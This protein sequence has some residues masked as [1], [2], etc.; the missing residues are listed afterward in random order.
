MGDDI[1]LAQQLAPVSSF[2]V[3]FSDFKKL[4]QI[5]SGAYSN[6]YLAIHIPSNY[7]VALKVLTSKKLEGTAKVYFVREVMILA[8]CNN[9]FLISLLGYTDTYPYCIA[10]PYVDNGSLYDA[11]KHNPGAPELDNTDKTIIAMCVAYGM[12]SLHALSIIHRD[13]KSLNILLD[14]NCLPKIIDFGISRFHGE[15]GELVTV[16]IGT[17]HWMAPEM[18]DSSHY[19]NKVDVYSFAILLWEML[20][21]ETPFEGM[22]AFQI[23]LG[24]TQNNQ[25]PPI[26]EDTP[27]GL[28]TLIENCW[29]SNPKDRP[30]FVEIFQTFA[31]H[32]AEFADTDQ[33]K[34]DA[35]VG[36]IQQ[37]EQSKSQQS[38][39]QQELFQQQIQQI[40][41]ENMKEPKLVTKSDKPKTVSD[42]ASN[43]HRRTS[44]RE[45]HTK[46]VKRQ[47][48][49]SNEP[50]TDEHVYSNEMHRNK[51]LQRQ[52]RDSD[53][54]LSNQIQFVRH[55]SYSPQ[56][57]DLLHANSYAPAAFLENSFGIDMSIITDTTSPSF[58]SNMRSITSQLTTY[59][60]EEFFQITADNL[61]HDLDEETAICIF[62]CVSKLL[63]K[64][65]TFLQSF[66]DTDC[67]EYM[68]CSTSQLCKSLLRIVLIISKVEPE[69]VPLRI[70]NESFQFANENAQR[71]VC[72]LSSFH[73][74]FS[75]NPNFQMI[76]QLYVANYAQLLVSDEAVNFLLV[77]YQ[78]YRSQ[79]T[80]TFISQV[81]SK[82]LLSNVPEVITTGYKSLCSMP[83]NFKQLPLEVIVSHFEYFPL[84]ATSIIA[85]MPTIPNSTRLVNGLLKAVNTVPL[86]LYLLCKITMSNKG[87][88]IFVENG[89]WLEPQRINIDSQLKIFLSIFQHPELRLPLIH[90]PYVIDM[91]IEVVEN[92]PIESIQ[93][94]VTAIRRISSQSPD[95]IQLLS[96]RGF[97]KEFIQTAF[98]QPS[99]E[100]ANCG[101]LL[102]DN[103]ARCAYVDDYLDIIPYFPTLLQMNQQLQ[104]ST[105]CTMLI[106][107]MHPQTLPVFKEHNIPEM[108]KKM[109]VPKMEEYQ[110]E[111]I[112]QFEN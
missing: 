55:G 34:V 15:Q 85:R 101:L 81:F 56:F 16:T 3:S 92:C 8:S 27:D 64:N 42:T 48:Y 11:L 52:N 22:T 105:L 17:P 49:G 82:S 61:R 31:N 65:Q 98:V 76:V 10:T 40:Q 84:E 20:T 29:E 88:M 80:F 12:A 102:F 109:N 90:K 66:L 94:I 23:M 37:D 59:Q 2:K 30:T 39:D 67:L 54:I 108:V 111:F 96:E 19:D 21:G 89:Q 36:F 110:K 107:T 1:P 9:P 60:A 41:E 73:T 106:L 53:D 100:M 78:I 24:V 5:G 74:S 104:A 44:R 95:F 35:L 57:G 68:S 112:Q 103:L 46:K 79:P 18:F 75:N 4:K 87:A 14:G 91:F 32:E 43:G 58:V 28:R 77:L 51:R 13:L 70:I 47:L 97:L 6:V 93:A 63:K 62:N 7:Q 72:L 69:L 83:F 45:H 86:A 50:K 38:E 26:P 25:R 71:L 99:T 33:S